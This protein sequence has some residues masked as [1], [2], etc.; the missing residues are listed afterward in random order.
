MALQLILV[1]YTAS[2]ILLWGSRVT[3]IVQILLSL[4][5]ASPDL[6]KRNTARETLLWWGAR[7]ATVRDVHGVAERPAVRILTTT[8]RNPHT[9][10]T[11]HEHAHMT[12][13]NVQRIPQ[14]DEEMDALSHEEYLAHEAV[15]FRE[16]RRVQERLAMREY[17]AMLEYMAELH[18]FMANEQ[19]RL[20]P[21]WRRVV[22]V[23]WWVN[24][25]V[26]VLAACIGSYSPRPHHH[27]Q[28]RRGVT[29]GAAY[30]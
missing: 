30:I 15:L 14:T 7:A 11:L 26:D 23:S 19:A 18:A 4:C 8:P 28:R 5:A 16:E 10:T 3:R 24:K 27:V 2:Q 17:L 21:W 9:H 22:R 13:T 25:V 6:R 29:S 20:I 1:P 12:A